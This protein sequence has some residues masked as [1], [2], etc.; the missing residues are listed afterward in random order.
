MPP[1]QGVVGPHDGICESSSF[2]RAWKHTKVAFDD[3]LPSPARHLAASTS[4]HAGSR[5]ESS[6][7]LHTLCS[8][9]VSLRVLCGRVVIT[10]HLTCA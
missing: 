2:P 10:G 3:A 8:S 4:Q 1:M 7:G 6:L 9:V 5:G